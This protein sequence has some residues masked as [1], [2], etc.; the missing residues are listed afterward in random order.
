MR[1]GPNKKYHHPGSNWRP[2]ACGANVITNYTM[3]AKALSIP[4]FE[5]GTFCMLG[6]RHDQLDHT[7]S[8]ARDERA[9]RRTRL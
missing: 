5:R 6:R 8:N 4:R 1:D 2:F 9:W 3:V 7:D